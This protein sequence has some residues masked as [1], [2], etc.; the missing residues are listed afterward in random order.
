VTPTR[1]SSSTDPPGTAILLTVVEGPDAI[2]EDWA[3]A[4]TAAGMLVEV[5]RNA[6]W[7]PYAGEPGGGGQELTEP[8]QFRPEF[9]A[10]S[11]DDIAAGGPGQRPPLTRRPARAHR[12]ERGGPRGRDRHQRAG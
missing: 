3:E 12:P 8:G 6:G 5:I 11:E 1:V 2:A 10:G 9:F 4:A 7:P